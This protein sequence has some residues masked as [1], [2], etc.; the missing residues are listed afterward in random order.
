M[1][2]KLSKGARYGIGAAVAVLVVTSFALIG[3]FE[4]TQ[5]KLKFLSFESKP[6]SQSSEKESF[7]SDR[8]NVGFQGE[9]LVDHIDWTA[10]ACQNLVD[11][12]Y[13]SGW[14]EPGWNEEQ[15]KSCL[16]RYSGHVVQADVPEATCE[17]AR[18]LFDELGGLS[19]WSERFGNSDLI[20]ECQQM[21]PHIWWPPT[22][23]QCREVADLWREGDFTQRHPN[24]RALVDK[25]DRAGLD[26]RA[27]T[28][29]NC[30]SVAADRLIYP[31]YEEY[32]AD[33]VALCS[34]DYPGAMS[35]PNESKC[36]SV[37]GA[38]DRL[39]GD[40]EDFRA[41]YGDVYVRWMQACEIAGLDYREL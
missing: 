41:R 15:I 33:L 36:R 29:N 37:S 10:E 38:W 17:A 34:E 31:N 35:F 23:E 12:Y 7:A 22:V 40:E 6:N 3:D 19:G 20:T 21:H 9:R 1:A 14:Q 24:L 13:E 16:K 32:N 30:R 5:G 39:G 27:V 18:I 26:Y 25:C 4:T 2:K 8:S 11:E 28:E